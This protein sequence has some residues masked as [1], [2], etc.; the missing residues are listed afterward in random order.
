MRQDRFA[1]GVNRDLLDLLGS[2]RLAVTCLVQS[3][4]CRVYQMAARIGFERV[5]QQMVERSQA[6][7]KAVEIV[8]TREYLAETFFAFEYGSGAGDS[9]LGK[10]RCA[11]SGRGGNRAMNALHR[12]A[13]LGVFDQAG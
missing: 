8:F 10:E 2:N 9:G 13:G 1:I 6:I 7:G 11:N 5:I 4:E 12:T 3:I